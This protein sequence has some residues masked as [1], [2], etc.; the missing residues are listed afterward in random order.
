MSYIVVIVSALA[1]FAAGWILRDILVPR[2]V[3]RGR[4]AP[5]PAGVTRQDRPDGSVVYSAEGGAGGRN[6]GAGG[7]G[8]GRAAG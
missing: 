1:G 4:P 2:G 8:D 6:G 5:A 7:K 3:H